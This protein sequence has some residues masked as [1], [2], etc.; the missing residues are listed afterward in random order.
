ME[1][2]LG[3]LMGENEVRPLISESSTS[4][5]TNVE[6][7]MNDLKDKIL[8]IPDYQRD[9]DQ[10]SEPTKSLFVESVINNL[11][12]PAFFFEVNVEG[13]IERNEVVD[14]Q[15]RLTTLFDFFNNDFALVDSQD[16]PY[17][18]PNSVHYAGKRFKELP[19][20]YQLAFKK[21]RLTV[22]KLRNLG[23]M[24]LEV[25]RRIN[26]GGTPLSGQDIR[27][28][29]WGEKSRSLALIRLVGIYDCD[30]QAARRF[31]D[32]AKAQFGLQY[33][34]TSKLAL[35]AWLEWWE[36]K[37]IARGQTASEVFLWTLVCAQAE[38][39]DSILTNKAALQKLNARFDRA[40]D[41]VLDVYAAQLRWQDTDTSTP[42]ALMAFDEMNSRFFPYFQTWIELL[43]GEKG[44]SL[45]VTKHRIVASLIG[46]AYKA[47]VD[48]K[49]FSEQQWTNVVEFVRRP[50]DLAK[51]LA[52]EWPLSKG[53]W[54]G[55][56]GYKVQMAAAYSIVRKIADVR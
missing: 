53:R 3:G 26:Q 11:S 9:S 47:K 45:P 52:E 30:R 35:D 28:A 41:E 1:F 16:A 54:D 6:V 19:Q 25:F 22:I 49:Q 39:L 29:Y 17:L 20:A 10:W 7:V 36:G 51:K 48:P 27:L 23:P 40:I 18:S 2:V 14:G 32:S 31:I 15:Q 55:L 38:E 37:E 24:R 50:Q 42:P 34:W 13:G 21:Y 12:I 46:A 44:T 4:E 5:S 43:L 56:R 33:P 8:T